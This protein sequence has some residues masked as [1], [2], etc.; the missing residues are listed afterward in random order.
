MFRRKK[1]VIPRRDVF[2][3]D[4]IFKI[5]GGTYE[6]GLK[7]KVIDITKEKIRVIIYSRD[8]SVKTETL[9]SQFNAEPFNDEK[10]A[11]STKDTTTTMELGKIIAGV[12]ELLYNGKDR[13]IFDIR[14]SNT[15]ISIEE[16][17]R[18]TEKMR[19]MFK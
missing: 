9:I 16:W 18:L 17:D 11:A 10:N 2:R 1:E 15:Q 8:G 7:A 19:R 3:I 6:K 12:A 5:T 14:N 4:L 13:D